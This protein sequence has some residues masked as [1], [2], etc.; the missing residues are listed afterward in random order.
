MIHRY[1]QT[2][3]RLLH[4]L[5]TGTRFSRTIHLLHD[6]NYRC[7]NIF[8]AQ[9]FDITPETSNNNSSGVSVA[10]RL[11]NQQILPGISPGSVCPRLVVCTSKSSHTAAPNQQKGQTSGKRA[12][13]GRFT[14]PPS[15]IRIMKATLIL[16]IGSSLAF[17]ILWL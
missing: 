13:H 3:L 7:G 15:K 16:F 4:P 6:P 12:R 14:K 17:Q 1:H 8:G 9:P 2:Q 10:Y 5:R 11:S